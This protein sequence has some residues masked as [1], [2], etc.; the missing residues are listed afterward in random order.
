MADAGEFAGVDW[1]GLPDRTPH[2]MDELADHWITNDEQNG[3]RHFWAWE[4]ADH[5]ANNYPTQALAFIVA[6]LTR[7]I[8]DQVRFSLAAGP[9]EVVLSHHGPGIISDVESLA[10][11]DARFR[12][13]LQGVSKLTMTDEVWQRIRV[14]RGDIDI[15]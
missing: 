7:P 9:L 1:A 14:A 4:A 5:L 8:G 15:A 12:D 10:R 3:E 13:T 11:L 6:T 2:D